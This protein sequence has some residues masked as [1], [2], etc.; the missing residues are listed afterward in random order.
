[1]SAS[2]IRRLSES[3]RSPMIVRNTLVEQEPH[4]SRKPTQQKI[5]GQGRIEIV[6]YAGDDGANSML[7]LERSN[8]LGFKPAFLPMRDQIQDR[9]AIAGDDDRLA[10]F[11]PPRQYRQAVLCLLDR[12]RGHRKNIATCGYH[13][14]TQG[15]VGLVKT[16]PTW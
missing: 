4:G 5:L 15:K 7:S 1:M 9:L 8:S 11:D 13:S 2:R 16:S 10:F 12:D 14:K 3:T 6:C